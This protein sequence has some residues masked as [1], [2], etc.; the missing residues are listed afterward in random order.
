MSI[1]PRW[2]YER[3]QFTGLRS[4]SRSGVGDEGRA[5][6]ALIM[7]EEEEEWHLRDKAFE[8]SF[9]QLKDGADSLFCL[10]VR[11]CFRRHQRQVTAS[12]AL[13]I[14]IRFTPR[15]RGCMSLEGITH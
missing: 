4:R 11:K 10:R 6:E 14:P 1:L 5:D 12:R 9:T 8:A 15:N 2:G 13:S 7:E 3:R